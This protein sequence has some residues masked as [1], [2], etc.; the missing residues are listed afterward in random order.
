MPFELYAVVCLSLYQ[1][2]AHGHESMPYIGLRIPYTRVEIC[3]HSKPLSSQLVYIYEE[4]L[5][6]RSFVYYSLNSHGGIFGL[7]K[8]HTRLLNLVPDIWIEC[9]RL[10]KGFQWCRGRLYTCKF[11]NWFTT[12]NNGKFELHSIRPEH[13]TMSVHQ[14]LQDW[15]FPVPKQTDNIDLQFPGPSQTKYLFINSNLI[16]S[17][18]SYLALYPLCSGSS[19]TGC[20]LAI[21]N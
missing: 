8:L 1:P 5:S 11:K 14:S 16:F 9:D 18:P 4:N 2:K 20:V 6:L 7:T 17:S 19:N 15:T 21:Y 3:G 12:S 13:K 10:S